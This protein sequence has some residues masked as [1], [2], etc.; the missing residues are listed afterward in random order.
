[1]KTKSY[2]LF[3]ILTL[4][5]FFL[6][7]DEAISEELS[8]AEAAHYPKERFPDI[9]FQTN[10]KSFRKAVFLDQQGI[11]QA[12]FYTQTQLGI[13][14]T[15][16]SQFKADHKT[17]HIDRS[18][19]KKV[20]GGGR[21]IQ[22]NLGF[23]LKKGLSAAIGYHQ[24]ISTVKW[25]DQDATMQNEKYQVD[26]EQNLHS[27][28]V[29]TSFYYNPLSTKPL[30]NISATPYAGIGFGFAYIES[31][32][33]GKILSSSEE[34]AKDFE[35]SRTVVEAPVLLDLGLNLGSNPL[36]TPIYAIDLGVKG[37][38]V[39]SARQASLYGGVK[40]SF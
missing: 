23:T 5:V 33:K 21:Y 11:D 16:I 15:A 7:S 38:V 37:M 20:K 4:N 39:G 17:Y 35:D 10:K 36:K 28:A 27:Q 22:T 29:I 13:S 1:M 18:G 34:L 8:Q 32:S 40:V 31:D 25:M 24:G 14:E 30:Y 9:E 12:R 2:L 19:S 3:F 26:L 6:F